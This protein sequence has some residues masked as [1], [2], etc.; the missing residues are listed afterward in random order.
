[1]LGVARPL[2]LATQ[3]IDIEPDFAEHFSCKFLYARAATRAA[4]TAR[5]TFS[6]LQRILQRAFSFILCNCSAQDIY[7]RSSYL[8]SMS[9]VSHHRE[10]F[11]RS[12]ERL[13]VGIQQDQAFQRVII[14]VYF[15]HRSVHTQIQTRQ[16]VAP[17]V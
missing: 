3:T 15:F 5:P 11:F 4:P 2:S 6:Q 9:L 17:A 8:I 1:M 7:F 12:I 14:T 13:T 10:H 16:L